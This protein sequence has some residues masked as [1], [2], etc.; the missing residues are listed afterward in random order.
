[1]RPPFQRNF[2]PTSDAARQ[3]R[4]MFYHHQPKVRPAPE[5][6]F[7]EEVVIRTPMQSI[8]QPNHGLVSL[9]L[10]EVNKSRERCNKVG[11]GIRYDRTSVRCPLYGPLS[12]L[13]L[14]DEDRNPFTTKPSEVLVTSF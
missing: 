1:M 9:P 6:M 8:P 12:P 4:P 2:T 13:A 7:R 3:E 10:R 14:V 11:I 5:S